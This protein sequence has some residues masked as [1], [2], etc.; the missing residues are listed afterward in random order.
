[1]IKPETCTVPLLFLVTSQVLPL[2]HKIEYKKKQK[3]LNDGE[4]QKRLINQPVFAIGDEKKKIE[5]FPA[6]F[7]LSQ[8][9]SETVF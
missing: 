8:T 4:K 6:Q 5:L 3:K 2:L 1:M 7:P 9:K